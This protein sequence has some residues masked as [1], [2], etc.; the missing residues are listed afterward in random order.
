[1]KMTQSDPR[2]RDRDVTGGE[3]GSEFGCFS[4]IAKVN[5]GE[6]KD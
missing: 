2:K 5:P 4:T 3:A 6:V 1:M